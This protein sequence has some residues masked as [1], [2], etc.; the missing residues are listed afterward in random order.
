M[1]DPPKVAS[2]KWRS[3]ARARIEWLQ[4]HEMRKKEKLEALLRHL[5]DEIA[6]VESLIENE[7]EVL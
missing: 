5:E 1:Q 4:K 6:R 2:A 7:N 3:M